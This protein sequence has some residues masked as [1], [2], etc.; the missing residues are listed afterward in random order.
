MRMDA[1]SGMF[2]MEGI[3]VEAADDATLA[4]RKNSLDGR[5]QCL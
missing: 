1:A 4:P 3:V 5:R 2:S